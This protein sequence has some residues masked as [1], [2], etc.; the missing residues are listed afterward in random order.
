MKTKANYPKL[1]YLGINNG[2]KIYLTAP[3][4]DCGWYWGFG[5]VGN[6]NCHYHVDSMEKNVPFYEAFEKHF[7]NSFIIRTSDRWT[8]SELFKSFYL[9]RQAAGMYHTGGAHLSTNPCKDVIKNKSEE[10]RINS[11]VLPAIFDE[12]Y[13]I[14][15]RNK[16]NSVLYKKVFDL[17]LIGD[18]SKVIDF[19]FKNGLNP[20]DIKNIKE[21]TKTDYYHIHGEYWKRY[22]AN[23]K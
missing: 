18:T 12:I 1:T 14:L 4:W 8:F 7:G 6:M 17:Y 23:K 19:M 22:H 10:D 3:S 2:E 20:D 16:N 9:L 5:Y 15:D 21:F 11:E 13:K